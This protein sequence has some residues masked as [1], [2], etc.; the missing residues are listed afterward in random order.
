MLILICSD[1]EVWVTIAMRYFLCHYK[2]TK[3]KIVYKNK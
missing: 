1:T 3:V 2:G